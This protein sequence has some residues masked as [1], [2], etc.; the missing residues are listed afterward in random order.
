MIRLYAT[1]TASVYKFREIYST[2]RMLSHMR[3]LSTSNYISRLICLS[4]QSLTP[5]F[6][7]SCQV[8]LPIQLVL[9]PVNPPSPGLPGSSPVATILC[10]RISPSGL[11]PIRCAAREDGSFR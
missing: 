3:S 11:N 8:T 4:T 6:S 10:I 1:L 2:T 7:Q 9:E 5:S